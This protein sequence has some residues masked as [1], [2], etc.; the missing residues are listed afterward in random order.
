MTE[1][2]IDNIDIPEETTSRKLAT[3]TTIKE[4][5]PIEGADRIEIATF[6]SNGWQCVVGK[7]EFRV[8]DKAIYFEIDSFLPKEERYSV[9]EGRCNKVLR[10]KEGYRIKTIKLKGEISQ[11]F[12]MPIQSNFPELIDKNL[13]TDGENVTDT[14]GIKLWELPIAG[15]FGFQI[16][17]PKGGFPHWLQK[18]DQERIQSMKNRQ[19]MD[20]F[21]H[22]FELT[23][24][25]DGTSCFQPT[26]SILMVDNS[27]KLICQIKPG[28]YVLGYDDIRGINVP[29]KVLN[30]FT[31]GKTNKWLSFVFKRQQKGWY[32]S[33]RCTPEHKIYTKNR[34]YIQA[35]DITTDD[36]VLFTTKRPAVTPIKKSILIGICLGDGS[37]IHT[38][39]NWK[40]EWSHKIDHIEYLQYIRQSLGNLMVETPEYEKRINISGYGTVMC[41]DTTSHNHSIN[42]EF[43][44]WVTDDGVYIPDDIH[45]DPIALAFWYMDDGSLAHSDRQC[46]RACIACNAYTDIETQRL[47]RALKQVGFSNYT[48]YQNKG[49][50]L[51]FNK[52][53][54]DKLFVMIREYVPECMQYKLP[55]YHRGY[56]KGI[57]DTNSECFLPIENQIIDIKTHIETNK[58]MMVKW[59]IETETHNFYA[60]RHLVHNCT[61][62]VYPKIGNYNDGDWTDLRFVVCSR[63][64]EL[65]ESGKETVDYIRQVQDD[66]E[67]L[68]T[69]TQD[70]EG[71]WIRKGTKEIEVNSVYWDMARKYHIHERL[72]TYCKENNTLLAL[73]GEICGP[74]IQKNPLGLT[75][76]QFFVFDIYDI[77]QQRYVSATKRIEIIAEMNKMYQDNPIQ[78]VPMLGY[79]K[80][81]PGI[82][83]IDQATN[84]AEAGADPEKV[85]DVFISSVISLVTKRL[86]EEA[87]GKSKIGSKEREGVVYKS[88]QNP[89]IS[90]KVISN[91]FLLKHEE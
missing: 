85:W 25:L 43:S 28:D 17:R 81:T 75:D 20:M 55:E 40:V 49:Y 21:G 16:G 30:V 59:D 72:G 13:L 60:S 69:D 91:K 36:I 33:F 1:Q 90:F 14:L 86:I 62:A 52:D 12:A 35:K 74:G 9:L 48:W 32:N 76:N 84:I 89:M 4:L 68:D 3:I 47:D 19:V 82:G 63:N 5:R 88:L 27:I 71:R 26:T 79:Q 57:R 15:G 6:T 64:L 22:D 77:T 2:I 42:H 8:G 50:N 39:T 56:F 78:M 24:K 83:D 46:D 73:Q 58:K 54:A 51:R 29:A 67:K 80:I 66:E 34:G 44:K 53:D 11:G 37:L 38:Q 41:R 18:T 31:T 23:E 65:K 61:I 45:L 87:E 70:E 7:G 10:G